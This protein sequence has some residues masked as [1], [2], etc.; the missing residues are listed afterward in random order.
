MGQVEL[1]SQEYPECD[2]VKVSASDS[3]VWFLCF[4][5]QNDGHERLVLNK[6]ESI[7]SARAILR[8]FGEGL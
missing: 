4:D 8:H 2:F 3:R 1:Y 5:V 7:E 6:E